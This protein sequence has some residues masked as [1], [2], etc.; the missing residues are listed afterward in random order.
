MQQKFTRGAAVML[1]AVTAGACTT[2]PVVPPILSLDGHACATQFD[3]I[4]ARALQPEDSVTVTLDEQTP[5]WQSADGAKSS[6][7]AFHLPAASAPYLAQV[8]SAPQDAHLLPPRLF[9]TDFQG[10]VVRQQPRESFLTHGVSLA[11]SIRIYPGDYALIIASDPASIGTQNAQIIGTTRTSTATAASAAGTA[12]FTM[13]TG[14]ERAVS[15]I[16]SH[17]GIVTVSVRPMPKND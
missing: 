12:T 1:L 14:D 8:T 17:N 15:S 11:A 10:N 16:G 4:S 5:C 7:L 3:L 9:I 13:H 2:H 6:Y